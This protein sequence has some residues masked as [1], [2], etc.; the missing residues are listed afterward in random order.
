[1]QPKNGQ[2]AE[3]IS[4][5]KVFMDV[6]EDAQRPLALRSA[7]HL[8]APNALRGQLQI[9]E[10]LEPHPRFVGGN[11]T[12]YLGIYRRQKV[13]VKLDCEVMPAPLISAAGSDKA[14]VE[15]DIQTIARSFEF[16]N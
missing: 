14:M 1:M 13:V 15:Q 12:M 6:S 4:D 2:P 16:L 9:F 8:D 11:S 7:G 5:E 10:H 3:S